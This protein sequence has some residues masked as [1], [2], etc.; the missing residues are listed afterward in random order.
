MLDISKLKNRKALVKLEDYNGNNEYLISLKTRME[1]EGSFFISPSVAEYIELNF[2]GAIIYKGEIKR[3]DGSSTS[4]TIWFTQDHII[5]NKIDASDPTINSDYYNNINSNGSNYQFESEDSNN[6]NIWDT[7]NYLRK[8]K[9]EPV[10]YFSNELEVR[11]NWDLNETFDLN[12]TQ[13]IN[14]TIN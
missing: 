9:P 11:A 6:N 13:S 8:I 3:A 14:D 12:K 4:D 1:K 7:G 5:R 2:D 10:Y